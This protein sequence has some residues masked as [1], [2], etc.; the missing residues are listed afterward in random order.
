M[1]V[2]VLEIVEVVTVVETVREVKVVVVVFSCSG[3][4]RE[5]H[6]KG[7]TEWTLLRLHFLQYL[8][9]AWRGENS[10]VCDYDAN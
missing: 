6:T 7:K 10:L 3:S 1:V 8:R 2:V 5:K 4:G 9:R